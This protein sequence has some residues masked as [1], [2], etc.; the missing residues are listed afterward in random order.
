MRYFNT[1]SVCNVVDITLYKFNYYD[2]LI[3]TKCLNQIDFIKIDESSIL[4]TPNQLRALFERNFKREIIKTR[5]ISFELI[6][7]EANSIYFINEL[8]KDFDNLKWIKL[9]QSKSRKFSRVVE[10][11]DH[12]E[13]R[14]SFRILKITLRLSDILD[15][16]QIQLLNPILKKYNLIK[17]KPYN[18]LRLDLILKA[19]DNSLNSEHITDV[20]ADLISLVMDIIDYKCEMDNPEV[21]LVTDW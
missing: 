2:N 11:K 7:K 13:L 18:K 8:L 5:S 19:F 4:I 14:F 6:H 15:F 12:K 21:I 9:T 20:Q 1:G 10:I 16:E 17:T 3:W